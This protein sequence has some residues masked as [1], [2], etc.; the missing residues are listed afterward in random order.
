MVH[1]AIIVGTQVE[2]TAD[3]PIR[4]GSCCDVLG[5]RRSLAAR[6]RVSSGFGKPRRYKT[7][8]Q[9]STTTGIGLPWHNT[10]DSQR[11]CWIGPQN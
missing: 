8:R 11:A 10:V 2:F 6:M 1:W 9:T 3:T 7:K 4:N 5:D